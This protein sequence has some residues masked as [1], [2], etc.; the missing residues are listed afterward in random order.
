MTGTRRAVVERDTERHHAR[1]GDTASLTRTGRC[2]GLGAVGA[3]RLTREREPVDHVGVDE[4]EH[5]ATRS[6]VVPP[7]GSG[8]HAEGSD[9]RGGASEE[10]GQPFALARQKG[11][12]NVKPTSAHAAP[13]I[14]RQAWI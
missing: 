1:P 12:S 5:E 9:R 8:D 11:R 3:P 13:G 14:R 7:Q 10:T 4:T 2:R 6:H